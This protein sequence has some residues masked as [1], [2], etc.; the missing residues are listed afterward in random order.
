M[1]SEM[2]KKKC[3]VFHVIIPAHYTLVKMKEVKSKNL[4]TSACLN[5]NYGTAKQKPKM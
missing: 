5:L 2:V 4:N 1:V 3:K